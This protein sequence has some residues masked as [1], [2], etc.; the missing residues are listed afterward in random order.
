MMPA[1]CLV[2]VRGPTHRLREET[3]FESLKGWGD[4]WMGRKAE[5]ETIVKLW[6]AVPSSCDQ[7]AMWSS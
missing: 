5:N 2:A 6:A 3:S 1:V 7:V 4:E